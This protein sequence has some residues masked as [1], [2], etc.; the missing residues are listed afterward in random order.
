MHKTEL[1][2]LLRQVF[3]GHGCHVSVVGVGVADAVVLRVT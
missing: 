1:F 3:E 2:V